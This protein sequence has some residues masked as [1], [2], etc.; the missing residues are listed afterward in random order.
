MDTLTNLCFLRLNFPLSVWKSTGIN[1]IKIGGPDVPIR[2][3]RGIVHVEA[4]EAGGRPVVHIAA[5]NQ[6][7]RPYSP[8][9]FYIV[10]LLFVS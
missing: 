4:E 1:F 6:S 3:R 7:T 2:I 5:R 10:L 8:Y 9:G